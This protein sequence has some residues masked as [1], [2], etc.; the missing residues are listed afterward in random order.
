MR[1]FHAE[2]E[3]EETC[4]VI[5]KSRVSWFFITPDVINVFNKARVFKRYGLESLKLIQT[6]GSK[7]SRDIFESFQVDLPRVTVLQ[8][9]ATMQ[10]EKRKR[11]DSAGFVIDHARVKIVD[12]ETTG[13]ALWP[14]ETGEL[15]CE[16]P[17][18]MPGY[19]RNPEAKS[20]LIDSESWIRSGDKAYY[21][22]AA[23]EVFAVERLKQVM[24]FRAY[25][26]SP[27]GN[28]A[29]SAARP[30][31]RNGSGCVAP[32]PHELDG[33]RAMAFVTRVASAAAAGSVGQEVTEEELI[34]LSATL[35]ESKKL[36]GRSAVRSRRCSGK[37]ARGELITM[38]KS[39]PPPSS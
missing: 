28:R 35:G 31:G 20:E 34:Q 12:T 27:H 24:K 16:S 29:S 5:E 7:I 18:M 15:Y 30:S 3:P 13:A 23:G 1:I 22:E 2:F 26:I 17:T 8:G 4:K 21:D 38:A 9:Y 25:H 19:P 36:R 39:L 32:V 33:E 6:G 37:I 14:N 11:V 10:T